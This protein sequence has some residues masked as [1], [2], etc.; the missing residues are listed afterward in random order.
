MKCRTS[1]KFCNGYKGVFIIMKKIKNGQ[2]L[3]FIVLAICF[4]S[5]LFIKGNVHAAEITTSQVSTEYIDY[6]TLN[7]S[8]QNEI[9][10][11][12]PKSI[13][14]HDHET[15]SLIYKKEENKNTV[16]PP[17]SSETPISSASI[18]NEVTLGSKKTG[19]LPQTGSRS[20]VLLYVLGG[21]III[22]TAFALYKWK[23]TKYFILI[24]LATGSF[25]EWRNVTA[26]TLN[27]L[28]STKTSTCTFGS[29]Y[30]KTVPSI[31]GYE[32]VGYLH[33]YT[34]N[35]KP[36]E[37]GEV[38]VQFVDETDKE[39][40]PSKHLTGIVGSQYITSPE[41]IDG[42][43][44]SVNPD[45]AKGQYTGT[46]QTV[47]YVYNKIDQSA[48]IIVK[49]VD[50]QGNPFVIPDFTTL[51]NG[52]FVPLYPNLTQYSAVLDYNGQTYNQKQAVEDITIPT[53]LGENYSLPKQVI[54][55]FKNEK[56]VI[57][58]PLVAQQKDYS[59]L[60]IHY[61][62]SYDTPDNISGVV[63]SK[64]IIVTYTIL[65]YAAKMPEP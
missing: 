11:G 48:S 25:T 37:N 32:Y 17:Q 27:N 26:E 59:L 19:S 64:E 61:W 7:E 45:N 18:S 10:K 2:R 49:F 1:L 9:I 29:D 5:V 23:R 47:K 55:H 38:I 35:S 54:F 53:K 65:A 31:S 60:G 15:F 33:N 46:P 50:Y 21:V 40:A 8:E 56:G 39:V 4:F 30:S 63:N 57:V 16:I 12:V 36:T 52:E 58:D 22:S 3:G 6:S 28:Q 20:D 13:I 44:L 51:Q 42:Y 24:L 41:K 34:D 14:E 43:T 62:Y